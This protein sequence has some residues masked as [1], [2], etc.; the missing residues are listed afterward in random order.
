MDRI[1]GR[2]LTPLPMD[3]LFGEL[4]RWVHVDR[5]YYYLECRR[6]TETWR[7]AIDWFEF[8]LTPR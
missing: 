6:G 4:R 2:L 5:F 8:D 3:V 1:D 7:S